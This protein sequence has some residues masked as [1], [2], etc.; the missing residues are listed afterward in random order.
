MKTGNKKKAVDVL[1]ILIIV[2]FSYSVIYHFATIGMDAH[3]DGYMFKT[4]LDLSHGKVMYRDTYSQ[5]GILT[6]YIQAF[7][8]LILGERVLSIRIATVIMYVLTFVIN[9]LI[10]KRYVNRV[11]A[12]I[13]N[14]I[15]VFMG[16]YYSVMFYFLPWSSVYSL[17]FMTLGVYCY[18]LYVE[19]EKIPFLCLC[20]ACS[21]C[22]F[23]CRQ[24]VG[25]V[26]VIAFYLM[27][28]IFM[29]IGTDSK[30]IIVKECRIYSLIL[31][32]IFFIFIIYLILSGSLTDFWIQ[33]I[34]YMAKFGTNQ[35]AMNNSSLI[36]S[37]VSC[38]LGKGWTGEYVWGM[39]AIINVIHFCVRV[40]YC[41]KKKAVS[42]EDKCILMLNM[43]ACASW[44]QYF[45]VP[46]TR[47]CYW[48]AFP[49][50]GIVLYSLISLCKK[51]YQRGDNENA[52]KI[53][54]VLYV[55]AMLLFLGI[56]GQVLWNRGSAIIE[57]SKIDY[58]EMEN[59]GYDFLD[60][61]RLSKEQRKFYYP[62]HKAIKLAV[63][64]TGKEVMNYSQHGYFAV[65]NN[66][67][68][69]KQYNNWGEEIY[70]DYEEIAQ[71]YIEDKEPIIIAASGMNIKDYHVY[72]TSS[73][74][75]GNYV[76][77]REISLY[78]HD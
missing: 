10:W 13:L 8:I 50:L 27:Q 63:E 65:F 9:Y 16:P 57:K 55:I 59:S 5:Y 33:N 58:E 60:G 36:K 75:I 61:L 2:I 76:G 28:F 21:I 1:N 41:K 35:G 6:S 49:M 26:L 46:C 32:I 43:Y 30:K 73:G 39:L 22:A 7:F 3:H 24:P 17:F 53:A 64:E 37:L 47:H 51:V 34:K 45:P 4:A 78:I 40:L 71:K 19:R 15:A 29:W 42:L 23:L 77:A 38:L 62:L 12:F 18:I 70:S 66:E 68:Y 54:V 48:G 52:K 14:I 74:D 25:M 69:H 11:N 44:H 20:A 56:N 31:F 67:N 72:F